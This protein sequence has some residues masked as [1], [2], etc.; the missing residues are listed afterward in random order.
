MSSSLERV[1]T[2]KK[3][4]KM[5]TDLGRKMKEPKTISKSMKETTEVWDWEEQ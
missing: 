4:K 3:K 2:G 1:E 5:R